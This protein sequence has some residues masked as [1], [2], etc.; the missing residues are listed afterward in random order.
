MASTT[1][2]VLSIRL[3]GSLVEAVQAIADQRG[4]TVS[5]AVRSALLAHMALD[6]RTRQYATLLY[7]IA[8]TRCVLL[9]LLDTQM[10]QA[11]VDHLLALAEGDATGYVRE[12]LDKEARPG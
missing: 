4:I 6:P 11:Q 12:I 3:P 5:E 10:T 1:T 2:Q 9:R 7:E 8:K